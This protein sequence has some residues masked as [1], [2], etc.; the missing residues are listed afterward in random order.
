MGSRRK[1]ATNANSGTAGGVLC[2]KGSYFLHGLQLILRPPQSGQNPTGQ[3]H[4]L[5]SDGDEDECELWG[6]SDDEEE[7]NEMVDIVGCG[8][9]SP[10]IDD[11][12]TT[13][14]SSFESQREWRFSALLR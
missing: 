6:W 12:V 2:Y 4:P 5:K 10:L 7:D 13:C 1:Q 11:R 3:S 8:S 14:E 9:A